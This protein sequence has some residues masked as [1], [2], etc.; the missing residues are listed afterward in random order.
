MPSH[1][2]DQLIS[3]SQDK[4]KKIDQKIKKVVDDG[5]REV[6][7]LNRKLEFLLQQTNPS[8]SCDSESPSDE[9]NDSEID[10]NVSFMF[11]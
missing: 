9:Y 5:I 8:Q 11:N 7:E 2:L 4:I 6:D 1:A 10:K 3:D